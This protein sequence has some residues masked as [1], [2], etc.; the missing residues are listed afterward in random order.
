MDILLIVGLKA[1]IGG[2]SA[3]KLAEVKLLLEYTPVLVVTLYGSFFG[4]SLSLS[5]K[6]GNKGTF[7]P[8]FL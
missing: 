8:Y 1:V 7:E 2:A 4:Q 5:E 3:L 6:R